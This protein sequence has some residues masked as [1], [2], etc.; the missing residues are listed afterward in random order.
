MPV[1]RWSDD[2]EAG[3]RLA[4]HGLTGLLSVDLECSESIGAVG[5][6]RT[7]RSITFT[8]RGDSSGLRAALAALHQFADGASYLVGH[9]I[10][11]HDLELLAKHASD[12]S[13]HNL[14]AIDTLYLS[15]LAF[16]EYPYHHLVKQYQEA[17]SVDPHVPVTIGSMP[18]Q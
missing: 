16:P 14:P 17:D 12:L 10:I 4:A 6:I 15:P 7:D 18:A 11:A 8:W 1:E 3:K 2:K 13:L 5:A 9:N